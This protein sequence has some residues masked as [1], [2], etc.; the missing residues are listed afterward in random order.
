[1]STFRHQRRKLFVNREIQGRILGRLTLYWIGYHVILWHAL[2]L[3]QWA[4]WQFQAI[5]EGTSVPFLQSYLA[6]LGNSYLVP[7]VALGIFPIVFWD[8]LKL[9]HRFAGPLIQLQN[10]LQEMTDGQPPQPVRFRR[11]DMLM[12]IEQ[13]F[14]DYV[15]SLHAQ[16]ADSG[17][18]EALS[19]EQ[20]SRLLQQVNAL[21]R[22]ARPDAAAAD[23]TAEPPEQTAIQ[24]ESEIGHSDE[25][26][27]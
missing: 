4:N 26:P 24:S 5:G 15:D 14:N 17:D 27:A 10:R 9:S 1:M 2:F 21:Q 7:L 3:T 25:Q 20:Y 18:C 22:T 11:D 19:E 8:M 6:F 23:V 16:A 12:E 13:T